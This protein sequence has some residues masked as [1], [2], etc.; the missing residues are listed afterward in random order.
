MLVQIVC[1]EDLRFVQNM[2]LSRLV[3]VFVHDV[4]I[5][6]REATALP[7]HM[8]PRQEVCGRGG[9]CNGDKYKYYIYRLLL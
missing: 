5:R 4:C 6:A 9:A 8:L 7:G 3:G 2:F 1:F